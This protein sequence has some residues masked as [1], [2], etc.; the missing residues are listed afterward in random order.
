MF[1]GLILLVTGVVF[2][3]KNLGYISEP[4]WGIIWPVV[5]IVIGLRI[6]LEKESGGFYWKEWI[7]WRKKEVKEEKVKG[8]KKSKNK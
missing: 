2:L 4:V 1:L 5:L 3:L 6:L 7:G 8:R